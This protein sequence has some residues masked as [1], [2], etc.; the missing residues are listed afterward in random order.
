MLSR[1]FA[2]LAM[3]RCLAYLAMSSILSGCALNGA[4]PPPRGDDG[5]AFMRIHPVLSHS[6]CVNCH[7]KGDS[8]RQGDIAR[9]HLP[10]IT[11]GPDD[12][13]PAG[14]HCDACHQASNFEPSGVPGAPNWHLAP[15]SMAWEGLTPGELCRLI[16]DRRRNGNKN[17]NQLVT[18]LT[19]DD[20][21]AWGWDP[22]RDIS[23]A[24][25]QPVPIPREEFKRLV[26]EW[27]SAGA[28]CPQ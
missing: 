15:A 12:H 1:P 22:G 24:A 14:L 13:G 26:H 11:R 19:E 17:L 20:L 16:L 2:G 5:A 27:A 18:H 10:P 4:T 21:V 28:S 23:G 7:P 9:L 6:R 8:P 3:R 25:R